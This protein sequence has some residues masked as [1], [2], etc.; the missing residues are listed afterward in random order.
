MIE[1]IKENLVEILIFGPLIVLTV[2]LIVIIGFSGSGNTS[3]HCSTTF[4]PIYNGRST[5]L[6]PIT[7]CY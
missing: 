2:V 1:W 7:R 6:I 3:T 5:T 4:I